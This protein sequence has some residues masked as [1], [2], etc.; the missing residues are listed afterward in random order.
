MSLRVAAFS[1]LYAALFVALFLGIDLSW[2]E[3]AVWR[4]GAERSTQGWFAVPD[5]S[6]DGQMSLSATQDGALRVRGGGL[7]EWGGLLVLPRRELT[8]A[9]L[10]PLNVPHIHRDH[11]DEASVALTFEARQDTDAPVA[12]VLV[13]AADRYTVEEA[14]IC[15][16]CSDAFLSTIEVT[17]EWRRYQVPL[18]DMRQ[19][20]W[21]EPARSSPDLE[22]LDHVGFRF[23]VNEEFDL[24]VRNVRLSRV[25]TP[26][27]SLAQQDGDTETAT[28]TDDDAVRNRR[29]PVSG[30]LS[31]TLSEGTQ[32]LAIGGR[33]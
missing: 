32:A 12:S 9:D 17:V 29:P 26:V 13:T 23:G 1:F 21:G 14:A 25:G 6:P 20:G 33:P 28:T 2:S 7:T 11:P 24:S 22:S 4:I 18:S 30:T 15:T 5:G 10:C 19:S 3:M 27:R 31:S 8:L 16:K